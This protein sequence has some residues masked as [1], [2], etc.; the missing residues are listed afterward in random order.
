MSLE[1]SVHTPSRIWAE[2]PWVSAAALSAVTSA[3][4]T[5]W[6]TI[7]SVVPESMMVV[8]AALPSSASPQRKGRRGDGVVTLLDDRCVTEACQI[9][10]LVCPPSVR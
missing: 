7:I 3:S 8:E 6:G 4:C 1:L 10:A 2:T 9:R 5:S